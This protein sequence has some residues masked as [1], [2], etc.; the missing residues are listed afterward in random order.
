MMFL[1][2]F[3]LVLMLQIPD[4]WCPNKLILPNETKDFPLPA[5]NM[6]FNFHNSVGLSY[7]AEEVRKCL[8]EG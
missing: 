8:K 1:N 7:E 3:K 5:S 4:F 6:T 2:F